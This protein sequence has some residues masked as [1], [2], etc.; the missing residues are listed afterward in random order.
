MAHRA[1]STVML[2]GSDQPEGGEVPT[3]CT[4]QGLC[5]LRTGCRAGRGYQG[6]LETENRNKHRKD[7]NRPWR[8]WQSDQVTGYF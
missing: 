2:F 4:C 7:K 1:D 6:L 5:L 3:G 8:G